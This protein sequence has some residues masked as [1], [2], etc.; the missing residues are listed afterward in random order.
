MKISSVKIKCLEFNNPYLSDDLF[1]SVCEQDISTSAAKL[2]HF[3]SLYTLNDFTDSL[4]HS[5]TD[6]LN[7]LLLKN[8]E[9]CF[10]NG[11]F[12][13]IY[14]DMKRDIQKSLCENVYLDLKYQ[15]T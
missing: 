2:S 13:Q 12:F 3:I 8:M 5:Q 9:K 4:V 11:Y 6:L 1:S 10:F 7:I 15:K 14:G